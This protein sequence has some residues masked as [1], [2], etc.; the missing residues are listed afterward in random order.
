MRA[1]FWIWTAVTFTFASGFNA[2]DNAKGSPKNIILF[3]TDD[4]DVTA[5]SIDPS[6][7]PKLNRLFREGGMEFP[8]YYVPTGL[9]CPS[10]TTILRGQYCHN[11]K[12]FDNGNL[13]NATYKSG[14]WKKFLEDGLEDETIATLMQ[15][16][17]Y[18]TA[19]IGKYMNGY[20][21]YNKEAGLHKPSGWDH[22]MGLLKCMKFYG[23]VFSDN[24]KRILRLNETVYQTDFIRDW[25]LDFL[26][27][28]RD[29]SKPFFLVVT[30]FAPH[31]PATPAHRHKDLFLDAKFPRYDSFNPPDEIQQQRAAWIKALPP[32]NQDQIDDMDNF[33][34]N[35]LRSLQ[36]VDEALESISD[37]LD[38]LGLTDDTYFI[39]TAD[40]GQH[41]GDHRIPAGKRQ[42]FE[43]DVLVP[44]FIRGPGITQGSSSSQVVQSVDLGPT[45]LELAS[46]QNDSSKIL[47]SSYPMDGK[48]I[49]PLL[50]TSPTLNSGYNDFRWAALLEMYGGSS[51]IGKRY[52]ET[53]GYYRNHMVRND[54][55]KSV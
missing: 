18:E 26:K 36:A 48:S 10:R 24:G 50:T 25:V 34:R 45:F 4:Q 42:A 35:R 38:E 3:M 5:N 2:T 22:W 29:S 30:P 8:N 6:I 41:F 55:R 21:L 27:N 19:L 28:R 16:A 37:T 52:K 31:T 7:M 17:G 20:D 43:S 9:C 51:T 39:Y 11:T 15:S 40:N 46:S 1:L 54:Y 12:I 49:L 32:L 44:F 13:N 33:Y 47:K 23:P 53:K 14:G